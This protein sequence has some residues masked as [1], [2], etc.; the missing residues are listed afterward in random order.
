M[1]LSGSRRVGRCSISGWWDELPARVG[2]LSRKGWVTRYSCAK[3]MIGTRTPAMRPISAAYIPP[4]LTTTSASMSPHSVL[5]PRTRPS[6][7][8]TSCTRV[9]VNTWQPPRRA[10]SISA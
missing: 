1:R 6:L 4:A 5:M 8:T 10:P 2:V 7:T 3:G 9:C